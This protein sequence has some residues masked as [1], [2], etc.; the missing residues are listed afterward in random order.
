MEF[1]FVGAVVEAADEEG[2]LGVAFDEA[3]F[4]RI[5][6][7]ALDSEIFIM[8]SYL[9]EFRRRPLFILRLL[10]DVLRG[11]VIELLAQVVLL[12]FFE[13]GVVDVGGDDGERGGVGHD[14]VELAGFSFWAG[15]LLAVF[16]GRPR[17]EEDVDVGRHVGLGNKAEF[18]GG[19]AAE[20]GHLEVGNHL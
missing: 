9:R 15:G 3:V 14:G 12:V 7:L 2:F 1:G 4:M 11:I 6:L 20:E 18:G 10:S 17:S 19:E 8:G 16:E 13:G 5:P